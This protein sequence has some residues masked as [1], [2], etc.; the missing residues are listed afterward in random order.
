MTGEN[1]IGSTPYMSKMLQKE[2]QNS[3]LYIV[4]KAKHMAVYEKASDVNLQISEF[5]Y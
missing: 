5:L 1:E 4:S 3:K 2:I